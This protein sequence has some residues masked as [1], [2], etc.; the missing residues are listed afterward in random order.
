MKK[1]ETIKRKIHFILQLS[2]RKQSETR[3]KKIIIIKKDK[4]KK[5]A[6]I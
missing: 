5:L 6:E 2:H 1:L 4:G 3:Q